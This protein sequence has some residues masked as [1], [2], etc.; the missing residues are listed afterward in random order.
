MNT[1]IHV[2]WRPGLSTYH[3]FGMTLEQF[4]SIF[5]GYYH[6]LKNFLYYKLGD[7]DLAED[8][9]QEVF[10]RAWDKRDNIV[11]ETV[12][13]YLY[14]IANNLAIN[15]FKSAR[16]RFEFKLD[17]HDSP[18]GESPEFVMEKEEFALRLNNA[19]AGLPEIQRIVF[20]MN[21]IDDLT[22]REI[23]ERLEI[24]VKAVEKRMQ[25]ALESLRDVIKS[26]F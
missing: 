1:N 5:D 20:L 22:Y 25:G 18:A 26:K 4:K 14:K 21:R 10:I 24:S 2:R 13:S 9:T 16:S 12:R 11:Q 8:M 3:Y 19:L 17:G 7:I 15:H 6:P 23:A